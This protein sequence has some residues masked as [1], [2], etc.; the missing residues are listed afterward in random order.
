[1]GKLFK[2]LTKITEFLRSHKNLAD[3]ASA[4]AVRI[5]AAVLAY[6]VQIFIVRFLAMEEYGIYVTL[7]TWLIIAK[8]IAVFGFSESSLRFLPRYTER[9]QYHWAIGFLKTGYWFSTLGAVF[10]SICG[11]CAIW[12][13][14][15]IISENYF[16]ALIVIASGLPI[17]AL[18]LYLEGVS[19]SFGWYML[20]IVPGYAIRPVLIAAGIFI[21]SGLGYE[22]NAA[23]VLAI[24]ILITAGIVITQSAII[25]SRIKKQFGSLKG[26]RPR[27]VWVTSSLPLVLSTG[28]DE[29]YYWSDILILGFMVPAPEVAIYFAAQ[30]SMS[31]ASFIQY[32][33]MMVSTR[34]FSL[35]SAMRDKIALQQR[36]ASATR[37][38]FWMTVPAVAITFVAGYPLLRLFGPEF[39][40]GLPIMG[41]L[42]FGLIIRASVGQASD[43][44]IV[45]GHQYA[46]M[47]VSAAGLMFNIIMSI[48]LIPYYGIMGAA[49]ATSITFALRSVALT[50][51]TKKLTGLWVFTSFPPVGPQN[52]AT[53]IGQTQKLVNSHAK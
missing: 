34:E 52:L 35:A 48:V 40:S 20:T 11:L 38:T 41:V 13:L 16:L 17:M 45:L 15:D 47:A 49:L 3:A 27:K 2:P 26:S 12:L 14:S 5:L 24:A 42:G 33:F 23:I 53:Q 9:K 44:L 22:L 18:E 7:L 4:M 36:V 30:R 28:V 46:N 10:V 6:G 19:R 32:A 51:I 25:L 43:L 37:W 39:L 8:F 21:V 1:M 50:I 31:L 29:L